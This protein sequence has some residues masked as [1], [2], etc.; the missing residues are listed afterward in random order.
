M[1]ELQAGLNNRF[2]DH[3]Y[4]KVSYRADFANRDRLLL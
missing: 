3:E 1:R 2:G 4:R